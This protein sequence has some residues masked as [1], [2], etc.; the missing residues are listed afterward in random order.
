MISELFAVT[1]TL[2]V[3]LFSLNKILPREALTKVEATWKFAH[4]L[5]SEILGISREED[6]DEE[7]EDDD[8]RSFSGKDFVTIDLTSVCI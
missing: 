3:S 8:E 4:L 5:A 6:E 2:D 1:T 7:E